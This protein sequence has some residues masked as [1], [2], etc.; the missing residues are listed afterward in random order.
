[1]AVT[2]SWAARSPQPLSRAEECT[3]KPMDV[4]RECEKCPEMVVAPAGTFTMGSPATEDGRLANEGPQT[5][6]TFAS[7]FAVGKFAVTFDEWDACVAGGGCNRAADNGKPRGRYPVVN[8]SWDDAQ[9]YVAW[10]SKTTGKPYRLL[11]EAEREYVTRA[12]ATTPFWWGASISTKQAN[13]DGTAKPYG[14]GAGE[15][16]TNRMAAQPVDRFD[17]NPFGLYQVHGNVS[18]WVIDCWRDAYRGTAANG[19]AW[20]AGD[21]GRHVVRGGSWFDAPQLLR[22]AA[23]RGFYPAYR[24]NTIG[25]RIARPL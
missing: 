20:T 2:L 9:A 10:L 23:R 6:V 1:V 13:Y 22:S 7:A 16:G 8:V 12:N 21:C 18:E 17:A 19:A 15:P 25:L 11:S 24:V 4:F 3:L 5:P 14:S